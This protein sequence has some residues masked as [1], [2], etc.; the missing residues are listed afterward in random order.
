MED[1]QVRDTMRRATT[2]ELFV[3]LSFASGTIAQIDLSFPDTKVS[4]PIM[5]LASNRLVNV[6]MKMAFRKTG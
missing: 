6:P 4:K 1:Y 2:P 3:K 5:L